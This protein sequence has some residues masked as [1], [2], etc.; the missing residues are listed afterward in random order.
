MA[1]E[2]RETPNMR[3]MDGPGSKIIPAFVGILL[4]LG[5]Y[6]LIR[7]FTACRELGFFDLAW[8][9]GALIAYERTS[10]F[11]GSVLFCPFMDAI[12]AVDEAGSEVE[13]KSGLGGA[14]DLAW[15]PDG[16]RIAISAGYAFRAG[17]SPKCTLAVYE[18]QDGSLGCLNEI[19]PVSVPTW[20][21]DG[22]RI[23]F[24][25]SDVAMNIIH[26]DGA[27]VTRVPYITATIHNSLSW[28]PDGAS[29]AFVSDRDGNYEI[30][31][32]H[33]DGDY[34]TKRLT[35]EPADDWSP[36]WSPDGTRI[37]FL[38]R[39][40]GYMGGPTPDAECGSPSGCGYPQTYTM[41]SDGTDVKLLIDAPAA[42]GHAK[43][44]PDGA[45]I[46]LVSERDG[47]PEICIVN[48]DGTGLVRLTDNQFNDASPA[49]SPDG[50]RIAF[51]SERNGH[52]NIYMIDTDGTNEVRLTKNPPNPLCLP[53]L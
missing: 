43:W 46:A 51:V 31:A 37:A 7:S 50:T 28:S 8:S 40:G 27:G 20:S 39:R 19:G 34:L 32:V 48:P 35:D 6:L 2:K 22:T 44:S 47:N 24:W 30:Y 42:D 49:W 45:R 52:L 21:P 14:V 26:T 3:K 5:A 53:I 41:K 23:A 16:R 17:Q 25:S 15:S 4:V 9:P 11:Y 1:L 38:S 12:Y 33:S 18:T 13:I 36:E 29:I 10:F